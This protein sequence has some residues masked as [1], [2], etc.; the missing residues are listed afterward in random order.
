MELTQE[1]IQFLQRQAEELELIKQKRKLA[2]EKYKNSEKGKET[3]KKVQ[4][5]YY[6]RRKE[7]LLNKA[8]SN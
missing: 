1:Q 7:K 4:H 8:I 3:I 5:N 2:M 6:V